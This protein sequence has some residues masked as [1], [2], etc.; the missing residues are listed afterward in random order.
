MYL[1]ILLTT[2]QPKR[3]PELCANVELWLAEVTSTEFSGNRTYDDYSVFSNVN[4]LKVFQTFFILSRLYTTMIYNSSFRL[5]A[6]CV[7][8]T[9]EE[10]HIGSHIPILN[11][12]IQWLDTKHERKTICK[13]TDI[14]LRE[15]YVNIEKCLLQ[16]LLNWWCNSCKDWTFNLPYTLNLEK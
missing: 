9:F 16:C 3:E 15:V 14:Y 12:H 8:D 11:I 4:I 6:K 10:R 2:A 5:L 13:S 7:T 1:Q